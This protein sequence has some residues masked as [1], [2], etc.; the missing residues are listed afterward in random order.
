MSAIILALFAAYCGVGAL[1]IY[2]ID[3]T[4]KLSGWRGEFAITLAA[5]IVALSWPRFAWQFGK[6]FIRNIHH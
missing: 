4:S 1:L 3:F 5:L 6:D 2:D